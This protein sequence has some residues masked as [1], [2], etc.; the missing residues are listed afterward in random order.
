[1]TCA[2]LNKSPELG[3]AATTALPWAGGFPPSAGPPEA[4]HCDHGT[5]KLPLGWA[6]LEISSADGGVAFHPQGSKVKVNYLT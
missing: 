6:G 5:W 4:R 1:M 3:T 2:F